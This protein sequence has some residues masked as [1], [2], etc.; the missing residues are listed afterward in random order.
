MTPFASM[1]TF[2]DPLLRPRADS[3]TGSTAYSTDSSGCVVCPST[4]GLCPQ[5][6]SGQEC[7][8]TSRTCKA[9]PEY[10]CVKSSSSKAISNVQVGGIVGGV[11]GGVVVLALALFLYY[12]LI[13][14]KKH[15]KL[16]GLDEI[17]YEMESQAG[18]GVSDM[19]EKSTG[20]IWRKPKTA[21]SLRT[22]RLCGRQEL[23]RV[24]YTSDLQKR[25]SVATSVSTDN[26]SN[27]LPI[28]Y[29]PGVTIRP[30]K[31]N[32]RLIFSYDTE[33]VF[34]DFT[35]LDAALIQERD[36]A[37][38]TMTAVKVQPRLV[39]VARIDEIAEEDEEDEKMDNDTLYWNLGLHTAANDSDSDVDSDIGEIKRATSTRRPHQGVLA[40]ENGDF[41]PERDDF[42]GYE[43]ADDGNQDDRD[44][45]SKSFVLDIA[46]E[47]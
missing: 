3:S 47:S 1:S 7:N 41:E 16:A 23:Q 37:K 27:I 10:T 15:P 18:D 14:R 17:N 31:N 5:C 39:N 40:S 46:R 28:A 13:Y 44:D 36:H 29:I 45:G 24:P 43:S 12:M 30:T 20:Q 35:G 32:T 19:G 42:D 21:D 9:C 6:P 2:T 34:S 11:V 33:S 4:A 22:S 26:A 38:N 8:L 25:H